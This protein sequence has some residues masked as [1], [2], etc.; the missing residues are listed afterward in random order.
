MKKSNKIAGIY[1]NISIIIFF[2][3]YK[4]NSIP[5]ETKI[6]HNYSEFINLIKND[7]LDNFNYVLSFDA[8][9][10]TNMYEK[11]GQNYKGWYKYICKNDSCIIIFDEFS[12][13]KKDSIDESNLNIKAHFYKFSTSKYDFNLELDRNKFYFEKEGKLIALKLNNNSVGQSKYGWQ[14]LAIIAI[15][16]CLL[17]FAL[18]KWD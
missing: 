6:I 7:E 2:L 9:Y 3:A 17:I 15:G 8:I 18:I 12:F 4:I 1:L 13:N 14:V 11:K 5:A 16:F 10:H